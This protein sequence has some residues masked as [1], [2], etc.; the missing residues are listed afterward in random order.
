MEKL[1]NH[2]IAFD[3]DILIN[4][5]TLENE[6][7]TGKSLWEAPAKII[8]LVENGS[9]N[10]VLCLTTI[11]ELRYVLHRKKHITREQIELLIKDLS[12]V[13]KIYPPDEISLLKSNKLQSAY[14][15]DPFDAILLSFCIHFEYKT[16][17]TR[18]TG[19]SDIAS[20]FIEVFTPEEF[21][22][23]YL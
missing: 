18:D 23:K 3:T 4:W 21:I 12:N 5:L 15:M 8:S 6:S 20:E 1:N 22:D 14:L 10:G 13:F 11:L 2:I 9:V 17:I 7:I 16:L 19:L